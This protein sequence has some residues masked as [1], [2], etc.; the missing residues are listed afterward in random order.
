MAESDDS[1]VLLRAAIAEYL[2][3]V[4]L[5]KKSKTLSAYTTALDYFAESCCKKL[6][7]PIS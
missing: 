3:E 5:S 6:N 1:R 2:D 7:A 4:K